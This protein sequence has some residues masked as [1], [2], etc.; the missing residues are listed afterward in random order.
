MS[1]LLKRRFYA[2]LL[3]LTFCL[4]TPIA[5]AV[6][7]S[8]LED[9]KN[10]WA[11]FSKSVSDIKIIQD[12]TLSTPDGNVQAVATV[13]IMGDRLRLETEN[14][15]GVK[16]A[17]VF[18]GT[19]TWM[20]STFMGTKK[21]DA[22][23]A[24]LYKRDCQFWNELVVRGRVIATQ[25]LGNYDTVIVETKN[26]KG[27]SFDL[28][29]ERGNFNL[30]QAESKNPAGIKTTWWNSNFKKVHAGWEIP[31]KTEVYQD[32]SLVATF[33]VK[34]VQI[35]QGISADFFNPPS[36]VAR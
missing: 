20:H 28:W 22:P 11:L 18:D 16:T 30:I 36:E 13:W 3:G 15:G 24:A 35:N 7:Q 29:I 26:K 23:E 34:S 12:M 4:S 17:V 5:V 6:E 10:Q 2:I 27:D 21:L 25:P 8:F 31:Y 14:S 19:E 32:D 33:V 9:A 1:H